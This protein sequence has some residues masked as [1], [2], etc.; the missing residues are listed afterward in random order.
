MRLRVA[1]QL[2]GEATRAANRKWLVRRI[3]WRMRSI[4]E[5]GLPASAIARARGLAS[6]ADLRTTAPKQRSLPAPRVPCLLHTRN[7][8]AAPLVPVVDLPDKVEVYVVELQFDLG[9]HAWRDDIPGQR[10]PRKG[11]GHVIRYVAAETFL[12]EAERHWATEAGHDDASA[13]VDRVR[14]LVL[15]PGSRLRHIGHP[16]EHLVLGLVREQALVAASVLAENILSRKRL[17]SRIRPRTAR[18]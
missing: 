18:G 3:I 17:R 16:A 15:M 5:C 4:E 7:A 6:G 9:F 10:C 13:A 1:D 12:S 14:R 11:V 2:T 8:D